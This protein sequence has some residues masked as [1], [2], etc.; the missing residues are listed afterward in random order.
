M[1][2]R[3]YR[4]EVQKWDLPL[5]IASSQPQC[6]LPALFLLFKPPSWGSEI[7]PNEDSETYICCTTDL[8][9]DNHLV[10]ERPIRVKQ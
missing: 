3:V 9:E 6:Y 2:C 4:P 5:G 1:V 8:H 10:I 7:V